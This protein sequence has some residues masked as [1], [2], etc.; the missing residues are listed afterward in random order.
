MTV[1]VHS[2]TIYRQMLISARFCRAALTAAL[3]RTDRAEAAASSIN[4]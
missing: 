2:Y 3:C 1:T 4:P